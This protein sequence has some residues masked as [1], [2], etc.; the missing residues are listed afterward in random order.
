MNKDNAIGISL[1]ALIIALIVC[2]LNIFISN[3]TFSSDESKA[4]ID[5]STQEITQEEISNEETSCMSDES[6]EDSIEDISSEEVSD[7]VESEDE[8]SN[9][10]SEE[11]TE[12]S[13]SEES[14]D[15]SEDNSTESSDSSDKFL[16]G[17]QPSNP[18]IVTDLNIRLFNDHAYG[19]NEE[20]GR[21]Y[22]D[23]IA[24]YLYQHAPTSM[25]LSA[26]LAQS[27]TEG[28][29]GKQ[30][31][32]TKTNNCFGIRAGSNW[33]GYVYARSTGLVYINYST[34]VTMG[35]RDLFRA[36]NSIEESVI[37]YVKLIQS[38]KYQNAL[39]YT[40]ANGYLSYLLSRNYGESYM[41]YTWL[42]VIHRYDLDTYNFIIE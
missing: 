11:S 4:S 37:D 20:D 1:I 17:F 30:G 23:T 41:L 21:V 10:N 12:I 42:S 28:G 35:G 31:V 15:N 40:T 24:S 39:T 3:D 16:S 32:Y 22:L 13:Q 9:E 14:K 38:E 6:S 33:N 19:Y 26:A 5:E 29:S 36:Y 8:T 34:A 2:C 27:Y 18:Y 25:V 7:D